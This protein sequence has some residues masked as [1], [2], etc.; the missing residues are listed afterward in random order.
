MKNEITHIEVFRLSGTDD[1]M[2]ELWVNNSKTPDVGFLYKSPED[3]FYAA[4]KHFKT[5]IPPPP[6]PIEWEEKIQKIKSEMFA[7]KRERWPFI[8]R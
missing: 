2:F 1:W 3:A 4:I 5:Y 8:W 7:E 6:D